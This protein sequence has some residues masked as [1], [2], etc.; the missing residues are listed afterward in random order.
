[1]KMRW[2]KWKK[3]Q[4]KPMNKKFNKNLIKLEKYSR[5]IMNREINLDH[6]LAN[7]LNCLYDI[8]FIVWLDIFLGK[9]N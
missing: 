8:I 3:S 4:K 2:N 6:F 1:M 5:K 7:L 9:N